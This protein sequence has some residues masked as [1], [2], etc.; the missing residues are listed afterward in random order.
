M[1]LLLAMSASGRVT[2]SRKRHQH[3]MNTT[4]MALSFVITVLNIVI[5]GLNGKI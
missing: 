3:R 5:T 4:A 2:P 1:I